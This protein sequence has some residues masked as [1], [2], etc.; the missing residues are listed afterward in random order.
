MTFE[1]FSRQ[2]RQVRA[3]A[4]D[5][6]PEPHPHYRRLSLLCVLP[7]VSFCE[8]A[9]AH[10]EPLGG[11]GFATGLLHPALGF[12]HFL[13]M[14]SVGILSAQIG[15]RAIWY[16]PATFV[17]VMTFGGALGMSA[18]P[19]PSVE[20]GIAVSV[21]ILGIALATERYVPTWIA[22]ACVA[23][24]GIFHGHAHGTEM[25][26]IANPWFYALGF[27]TGTAVIHVC[28]VLVGLGSRRLRRGETYLRVLGV[29]IATAGAYLV[30][31][32]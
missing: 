9:L 10:E 6:L 17:L 5:A 13:A 8:V 14:L 24:F 3:D 18:V 11:A 25:P 27:V 23:V 32:L 29:A 20:L 2:A 31:S 19:V 21:L 1:A 26:V 16:V 22:F 15:G 30:V 28:G 7:M 4:G 12:D